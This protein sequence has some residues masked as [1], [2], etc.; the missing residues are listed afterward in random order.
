MPDS[1]RQYCRRI[2]SQAVSIATS[3]TCDSTV[4]IWRTRI[5]IGIL[6]NKNTYMYSAVSLKIRGCAR[7]YAAALHTPLYRVNVSIV[8]L[9]DQYW[10]SR[11]M[12]M[13]LLH[14][15]FTVLLTVIKY[16]TSF[17]NIYLASRNPHPSYMYCKS[18]HF[19][20]SVRNLPFPEYNNYTLEIS[21]G[22]IW[23]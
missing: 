7:L 14:S 13:L 1:T 12:N 4:F 20:E 3:S 5:F 22:D 11:Y 19:R 21:N 9:G 16:W 10:S 15:S 8:I 17:F 2:C 18:R 6:K 23:A